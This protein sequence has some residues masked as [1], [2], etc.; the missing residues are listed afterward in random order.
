MI[1]RPFNSRNAV[2][3]LTDLGRWYANH[4]DHETLVEVFGQLVDELQDQDVSLSAIAIRFQIFNLQIGRRIQYLRTKGRDTFLYTQLLIQVENICND[5][6]LRVA[7]SLA[8]P[9]LSLPPNPLTN[10]KRI[11][12]SVSFC[13]RCSQPLLGSSMDPCARCNVELLTNRI[14]SEF[15]SIA[16]ILDIKTTGLD[17]LQD[18]PIEIAVTDLH[19]YAFF[20]SPIR[21][22]DPER[23]LYFHQSRDTS[24]MDIHGITP[25]MFDLALSIPEAY[26]QLALTLNG[27]YVI[28]YN[29]NFLWPILI[30]ACRDYGLPDFRPK[31]GACALQLYGQWLTRQ[32]WRDIAGFRRPLP[33]AKHRAF[34]DTYAILSLI[35]SFAGVYDLQP[36]DG[37]LYR[38]S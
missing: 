36:S 29:M 15:G 8:R 18:R 2:P 10:T 24:A 20:N 25:R 33:G 19:G 35:S 16:R 27:A 14:F 22:P 11:R 9:V 26:S 31:W 5:I 7:E 12:K 37:N 1:P 4:L 30:S 34:S 6:R 3:T 13:S 38:I 21:P 32:P 17:P 23:M 28:I